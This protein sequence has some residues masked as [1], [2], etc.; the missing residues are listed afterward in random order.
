MDQPTPNKSQYQHTLRLPSGGTAA[1]CQATVKSTGLQCGKPATKSFKVCASHGSG[2]PKK[3]R[4][5]KKLDPRDAGF[6]GASAGR[7]EAERRRGSA[8]AG[9][10][11][12]KAI[13]ESMLELLALDDHDNTDMEL[14]GV[15]AVFWK[16]IEGSQ[17]QE[18]AARELALLLK[19]F[20]RVRPSNLEE[21]KALRKLIKTVST[22]Q[23]NFTHYLER[24]QKAGLNVVKVV[25]K[26]ASTRVKGLQVRLLEEFGR[27]VIHIRD[28]LYE[29]CR[30]PRVI[31]AFERELR[32][33]VLDH[34]PLTVDLPVL[35]F[36]EDPLEVAMRPVVVADAPPVSAAARVALDMRLF[37]DDSPDVVVSREDFESWIAQLGGLH[38]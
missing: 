11:Y 1:R 31:D 32:T 20:S 12:T 37:L 8:I 29:A 13:D 14:A 21:T 16:L 18:S 23:L 26:R 2:Y 35:D 24:V 28:A 3:V 9:R 34:L 19:E 30:D 33:R 15:R 5:G 7:A 38:N 27:W 22:L 17:A 36:E 4:A 10:V 25:E 6:L